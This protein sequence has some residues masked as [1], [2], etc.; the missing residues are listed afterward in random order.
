MASLLRSLAGA[1]SLSALV[2]ACDDP[3]RD[4]E[5]LQTHERPHLDMPEGVLPTTVEEPAATVEEAAAL[6]MPTLPTDAESHDAGRTAYLRYCSHCHGSHGRGWTAVGSSLD[7]A[8]ADLVDVAEVMSD[9]ELFGV[10]TFGSGTTP[11]LRSVVSVEDRWRI[12]RQ[13]RTLLQQR[14][15]LAPAWSQ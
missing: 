15:G 13:V 7:P 1:L 14:E 9:G 2:L 12:I 6:Q 4:Q 5:S 8:P 10:I 3:L 11:A